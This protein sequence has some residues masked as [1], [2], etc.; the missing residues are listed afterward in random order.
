MRP[1]PG[2]L[3][4]KMSN[5]IETIPK[6]MVTTTHDGALLSS[7]SLRHKVHKLKANLG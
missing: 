5:Q 4:L 7:L 2:Q 6:E 3:K 1:K